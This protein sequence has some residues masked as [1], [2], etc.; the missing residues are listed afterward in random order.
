MKGQHAIVVGAGFG[1]L[2]AALV[3]ATRG[4]KVTVI[5]AAD[6]PGGKAGRVTVDGVSFDTGPSLFT[7]PEVLEMLLALAGTRLDEALTLKRCSPAFRYRYPDGT[8]LDIEDSLTGRASRFSRVWVR[9][10]R[11]N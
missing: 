2:A 7:L 10:L 3:L 11:A 5:E 8:C 6:I 1:G 9:N 4:M